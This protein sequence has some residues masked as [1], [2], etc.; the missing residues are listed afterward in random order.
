M[1]GV[2]DMLQGGISL[3]TPQTWARWP[4]GL[5]MMLYH[6]SADGICDVEASKRFFNGVEATHK[7]LEIIEVSLD[8]PYPETVWQRKAELT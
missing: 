3:D 2:A 7:R 5:P 4:K 1:L 8:F 6:G